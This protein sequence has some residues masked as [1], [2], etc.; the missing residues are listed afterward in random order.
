MGKIYVGQHLRLT[1]TGYVSVVGGS[2][3]I[4]YLRPGSAVVEEIPATILDDSMAVCEA[5]LTPAIT[6]APGWWRFWLKLTFADA[7]IGIGE[8]FRLRLFSAG[9]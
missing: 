5:L 7:T 8:T 6:T 4:Q 2:A 1:L 3:I 9:A